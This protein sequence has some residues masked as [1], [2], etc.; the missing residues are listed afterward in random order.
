MEKLINQ[1]KDLQFEYN[2]GM[3]E[4]SERDLLIEQDEIIERIKSLM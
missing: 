2:L 4:C 1:L 3:Y